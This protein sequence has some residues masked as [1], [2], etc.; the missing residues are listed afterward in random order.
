MRKERKNMTE[1]EGEGGR[2]EGKVRGRKGGQAC[3]CNLLT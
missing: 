3:W 1:S 2:K